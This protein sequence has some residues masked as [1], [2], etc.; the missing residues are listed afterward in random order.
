L[1]ALI[2]GSVTPDTW[3]LVPFAVDRAQTHGIP[4]LF[5]FCVPA[6][7]ALY[8]LFHLVLKLPLVAL[9]PRSLS[10]RLASRIAGQP[11]LPPAPWTAVVVSVFAGAATHQA[12]DSFTHPA[13]RLVRAL[14]L[15]RHELFTVGQSDVY[16]STILQYGA[17]IA[18][19][20]LVAAW[21]WR[22]LIASPV[23]TPPHGLA[24]AARIAVISALFAVVL[25]TAAQATMTASELPGMEYSLMRGYVRPA[26]LA[27]SQAVAAGL[28]AYS[29][30]WHSV[31]V[32]L[33]PSKKC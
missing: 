32:L 18:G 15:L 14:P 4:G 19:V 10:S 23:R 28:L 7:C 8:L 24:P 31:R 3:Y 13:G 6:G 29:L 30:L 21:S 12:L 27:A 20:A 11:A 22:W 17:G 9:M 2:V 5:W 33:A 1:S 25:A 16:V 26:F